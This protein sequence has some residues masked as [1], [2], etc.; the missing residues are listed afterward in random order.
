MLICCW[1]FKWTVGSFIMILTKCLWEIRYVFICYVIF[2]ILE[3]DIYKR[4]FIFNPICS[5]LSCL[6]VPFIVPFHTWMMCF[7]WPII[8]TKINLMRLGLIHVWYVSIRIFVCLR[9]TLVLE[10]V[11]GVK[12]VGLIRDF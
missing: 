10:R 4:K 6:V 1:F 5:C 3:K 8:L 12:I 11:K 2:V 7:E 9:Y